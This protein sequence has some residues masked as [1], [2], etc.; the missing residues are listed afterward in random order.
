MGPRRTS[1]SR[2]RASARCYMVETYRFLVTVTVDTENEL[3]PTPEEFEETI[4]TS[5]TA[6]GYESEY[7][8]KSFAIERVWPDEI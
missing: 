1:S 8:L 7:G 4:R 3:T 6:G 5:M 2:W